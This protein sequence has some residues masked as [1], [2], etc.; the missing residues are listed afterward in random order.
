MAAVERDNRLLL[1]RLGKAMDSHNIDNFMEPV[2]FASVQ[3]ENRKNELRRITAD[4]LRLLNRIQ[5]TDPVYKAIEWERDA[6][7][8]EKYLA[9]MSEF[10]EMFVPKY[11]PSKQFQRA[12]TKFHEVVASSPLLSGARA[13]SGMFSPVQ[14]PFIN[15]PDGSPT[16]NGL[17]RPL[18]HE[19]LTY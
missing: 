17:L 14:S 18:S 3:A 7:Q 8:R 4:N 12:K 10:P 9:S 13:A 19:N 15:P 11:T 1:D 2:K 16:R 5:N 6:E